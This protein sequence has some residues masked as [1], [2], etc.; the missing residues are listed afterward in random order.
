MAL[1]FGFTGMDP[2]TESSLKAAF[3]EANA[4]GGNRWQ[5]LPESA[6][7]FVAVDMDSMYGPM[8]WL[9]LHA[10]GK[11][12]IGLTS[13]SRVQT[14]FRLERPFD[15]ASVAALLQQLDDGAGAA[16][17]DIGPPGAEVPRTDHHAPSPAGMTPA[18]QPQDRLP[19]E[20]PPVLDEEVA[21]PAEPLAAVAPDAVATLDTREP[22]SA[23]AGQLVPPAPTLQPHIPAQPRTLADWLL[24]GRLSGHLR[25]E[26]NGTPLLIDVVQRHYHGPSTLKTIAG[27]FTGDATLADFQALNDEPAWA[28]QRAV[29]GEAQPLSRLVWFG[30]LL[31]GQGTLAPG[32]DAQARYRLLKWPQTEREFPKHFRVATAMMKGPAT[33]PE[34]AEASG[35]PLAHVTDF[36]NASLATGFA[37]PYREPEPDVEPPK[38]SGLFNR[39]RGR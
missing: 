36:V 18:P 33:L 38:P 9:R 20:L 24:S 5:L 26:R 11:R 31:A 39:L 16:T 32:Y 29:L 23:A 27:H 2:A 8:S 1:T 3:T 30:A 4:R 13:A 21:A 7:D 19:E 15:S 22:P 34:I 35:V 10:A 12:V 14:D 37:E 6:A 17:V 25:F 28:A